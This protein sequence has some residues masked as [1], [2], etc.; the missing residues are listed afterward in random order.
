MADQE[1]TIDQYI[2]A[3]K[4]AGEVIEGIEGILGGGG[5]KDAPKSPEDIS[6]GATAGATQEPATPSP[7]GGIL[8]QRQAAKGANGA[9][10]ALGIAGGLGALIGL[11]ALLVALSRRKRKG[12]G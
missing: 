11:G 3:M 1:L 7:Y 8:R 10:I 5:G 9:A 6:W 12:E 4:Q 2:E